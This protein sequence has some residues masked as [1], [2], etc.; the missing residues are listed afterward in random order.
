MYHGINNRYS[1]SKY[2]LSPNTSFNGGSVTI[3]DDLPNRILL[4]SVNMKTEVEKFTENGAVFVDGTELEDIDVVILATGFN[5]SFS[6]I[7]K[8][9][10]RKEREFLLLYDLVWPADLEPATLTIIGLVQPFGGLPP[11]NEMQARWATRVFSGNC[12]LPS[13]SKRL[14]MVEEHNARLKSKGVVSAKGIITVFF[15]QY[16]DRIAQYI[17]CKP[18]LWKLFFTDNA[19]WR[20]LVFGPCTPSQWRLE[21]FG[22]WEGAKNAIEHVDDR[23]WYPMQSREA[24]KREQEGIYD[25]YVSLLKNV[26]LLIAVF[27]LLR[28]LFV[29]VLT[30][31]LVN[32]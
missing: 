20:R 25:G 1:H 21:G 30:T 3:S 28:F 9:V 13:T 14:Q 8:D 16:V 10:I 29:N 17:G 7:Q 27:F 31:F 23:T 24:G 5:Y 22:K 19:L 15:I 12:K 32:F 2:G 18:N 6:F 26:L 4:G 11:V